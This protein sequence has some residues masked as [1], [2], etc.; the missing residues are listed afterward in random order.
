M[1]PPAF[2]VSLVDAGH[3]AQTLWLQGNVSAPSRERSWH[4]MPLQDEQ[5]K[6]KAPGHWER[7]ETF[8]GRSFI[9]EKHS[10]VEKPQKVTDSLGKLIV[11]LGR[12]G[13]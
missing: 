6:Q 2:P 9:P 7:S 3:R 12:G 11:H 10:L 5:G 13:C 8:K 4:G 1:C